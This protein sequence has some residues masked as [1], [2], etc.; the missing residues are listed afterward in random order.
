MIQLIWE[1][2]YISNGEGEVVKNPSSL[3]RT[4]SQLLWGAINL[5][6]ESKERNILNILIIVSSKYKTPITMEEEKN[7]NH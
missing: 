7:M 3:N 1:N 4:L 5:A 2:H 6:E